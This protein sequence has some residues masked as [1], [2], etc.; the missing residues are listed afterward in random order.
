MGD[1]ERE[2]KSVCVC[3]QGD[4]SRVNVRTDVFVYVKAS[5]VYP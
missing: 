2:E 1:R 3:M 4:F 5:T